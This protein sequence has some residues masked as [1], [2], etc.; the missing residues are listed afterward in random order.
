[1][2]SRALFLYALFTVLAVTLC[3]FASPVPSNSTEEL[4]KRVTHTGRVSRPL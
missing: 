2:Q 1:M 3:A 4:E